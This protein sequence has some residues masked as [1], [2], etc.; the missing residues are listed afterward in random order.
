[1]V[2][3]AT[4]YAAFANLPDGERIRFDDFVNA[5]AKKYGLEPVDWLRKIWYHEQAAV[6]GEYVALTLTEALCRIAPMLYLNGED[7]P[8]L[9]EK[10]RSQGADAG[11][12]GKDG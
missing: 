8:A 7:T 2:S 12:G 1:M 3:Q 10:L 5:Q 4:F 9:V 6:L 11:T